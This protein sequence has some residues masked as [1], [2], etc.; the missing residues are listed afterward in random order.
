MNRNS[1]IS[2][3]K[4]NQRSLRRYLVAL[5]NGDISLADDIAQDTYVKAYLASDTFRDE[6]KF[7]AWIYKIAYNTYLNSR[8]TLHQSEGIE[9]IQDKIADQNND[10][11][12]KYQELY[13]SLESLSETERS[14]ILLFYM[15]GYNTKEISQ[16]IDVSESNVRQLLSRG[17]KKLKCILNGK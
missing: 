5:C 11:P 16:I 8:R 17:R 6:T 14:A 9:N 4:S 13:S 3:V 10:E 1:F 12:F 2:Y 7:T 15:Q